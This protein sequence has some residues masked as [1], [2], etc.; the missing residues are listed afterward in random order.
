MINELIKINWNNVTNKDNVIPASY[1][2]Y[3][4]GRMIYARNGKDGTID[5]KGTDIAAVM[6]SIM[7]TTNNGE[8]IFIKEGDYRSLSHIDINNNMYIEGSGDATVL[9]LGQGKSIRI[10]GKN[11]IKISNLLIDG[12]DHIPFDYAIYA[13]DFNNLNVDKVTIRDAKGFGIYATAYNSSEKL[14]VSN[15]ILNGLGNNDVIGGG[16]DKSGTFKLKDVVIKNNF[17]EQYANVGTLYDAAIDIVGV[18]RTE[19]INNIIYGVVAFG[20]EQYPHK[21]SMIS[22]NIIKTPVGK[23]NTYLAITTTSD[24]K[25]NTEEIMITNNIIENGYI[26]LSGVPTAYVLACIINNNVINAGGSPYAIQ[27]QNASLINIENNMMSAGNTL[28]TTCINLDVTSKINISGNIM[29]GFSVGIDENFN[30]NDNLITDNIFDNVTTKIVRK[31]IKTK[32]LRNKGYITENNILSETFAIDSMGIK[33][34]MIVHSLDITPAIQ[35]CYLT[36]IKHTNVLDWAYN[37]LIIDSVDAT[38]L[39]VKINISI[40]SKTVGARARLALKIGN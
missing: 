8:K 35:D 3:K 39:I 12:S 5:F 21:Y 6:N 2:I 28:E 32:I 36:V 27:L 31:S 1:I 24:A 4:N 37:L 20:N 15:C 29:T 14:I 25:I 7:S 18:Y 26:I 34:V 11:N 17:I 38:N 10:I 33:T 16:P 23:D 40:A 30:S 19:I 13:N 22:G 9:A